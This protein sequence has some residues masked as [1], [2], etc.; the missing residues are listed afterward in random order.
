MSVAADFVTSARGA[1]AR[2]KSIGREQLKRRAD[3]ERRI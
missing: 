2:P 3:V 1:D